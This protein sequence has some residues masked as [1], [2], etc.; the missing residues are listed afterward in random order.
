MRKYINTRLIKA[1]CITLLLAVSGTSAFALPPDPDNAALVYY[2]A[3]LLYE[4]PDQTTRGLLKD[5]SQGNMEPN[6]KIIEY[7]EGC[8]TSLELAMVASEIPMCNW[9][10]RY[11]QGFEANLPFLGQARSLY[12]LI[13][14]DARIL[15]AEGDY[16]EALSRCLAAKR[17]GQH[18]GDN[19]IIS[20]FVAISID[21]GANNCIRDILGSQPADI[22]TLQWLKTQLATVPTRTLSVNHALKLEREVGMQT[23]QVENTDMLVETLTG[24]GIEVTDKMLEAVDEKSLE[25]GREHYSNHM[26]AM[27]NILSASMTYTKKYREL[28][29]LDERSKT[30]VEDNTDAALTAFLAPAAAKAYS[31]SVRAHALNNATR[32][33]IDVYIIKA[34]TGKLPDGL[35]PDSPKDPFSG[36]DFE[37]QV[38][39]NG[40]ILRC[41]AVDLEKDETHQY[42]FKVKK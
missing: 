28:E 31:L 9:G 34:R 14:A 19:V 1:V 29:K 6:E 24:A 30:E 13:I 3:F 32:T 23:M 38:T 17:M 36:R 42:E 39:K 35:P 22:E 41:Q 15:A 40:F 8:H 10:V 37:Y 26:S 2:Q 5:L 33:A 12:F 20:V 21:K 7:V 18:M 16:N 4:Q 25:K 11:S 27:Q